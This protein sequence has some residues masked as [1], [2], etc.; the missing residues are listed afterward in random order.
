MQVQTLPGPPISG[1]PEL[2]WP[3]ILADLHGLHGL[4]LK[5]LKE[6]GIASRG[7]TAKG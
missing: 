5:E 6:A 1:L 4:I 2:L 7:L 3:R